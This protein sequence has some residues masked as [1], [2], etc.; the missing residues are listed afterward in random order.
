M[1]MTEGVLNTPRRPK[2][3]WKVVVALAMTAAVIASAC[4]SRAAPPASPKLVVEGN[5]TSPVAL[6]PNPKITAMIYALWPNTTT[7]AWPLYTIP[8]EVAAFKQY[9]PNAHLVQLVG[10]NDQALQQTQVEAAITAKADAVVFS[11][12]VPTAAGG[13]LKQFSEAK[14]P[15]IALRQDPIG[16]PVNSYVW[17]D[18]E[19]V[20]KFWGDFLTHHLVADVGH[21]PVRLAEILG[22][23]TFEVYNRWSN[24]IS[25]ALNALISRGQVQIVCKTDTKGFV[26]ASAQA[27]MDQCLTT[28]AGNVDA[29]LVMQDSTGNGVAA[30]LASQGL[31]GKVRFYGG[32]DGDV[33]ALQRVLLGYQY[34]TFHPDGKQTALATVALVVAALEGKTPQST[35]YIN[36]KFLNGFYPGGVPTYLAPETLVTAANMQKTVVDDGFL[37]KDKICTV[38]VANT[39]FCKGP[40]T[41]GSK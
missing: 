28:T 41:G 19:G 14:I 3:S 16:G 7:P 27:E 15:V 10:N 39:P 38:A 37:P 8:S 32:H 18:F 2:N 17:V 31:L 36:A 1:R 11:P 34:G 23:P 40:S 29:V 24:G 6:V 33:M 35:G 4:T 9:L 5:P 21:K 26:P 25:P 30:S 22:D 12:V 20:G 13:A